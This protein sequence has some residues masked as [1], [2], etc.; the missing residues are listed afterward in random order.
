MAV[1]FYWF[2]ES[3]H[4]LEEESSFRIITGSVFIFFLPGLVWGEVLGF[5]SSHPLETMTLSF[6]LTLSIEVFMLPLPFLFGAP[7]QLWL[8]LIFVVCA[9]GIVLL[10]L[11]GE[12]K[13]SSSFFNGYKQPYPLNVS[14][15]LII[16]TIIIISSAMY[17]WGEALFDIRGEKLLEMF[18]VRYYY[19]LPLHLDSFGV[20][21]GA[22]PPNM[23]HLWEF[24][25]AGWSR[26]IN[27]DPLPLFYRAR[28]II[29]L[30]GYSGMYFLIKNIFSCKVKAE[31]IFWGVIIMSI[32]WFMLFSEFE[33]IR[34]D[35]SRG[36]M[37]FMETVHHGDASTGILIALTAGLLLF[38]F[39]NPDWKNFFIITGVLAANFMWHEREFFQAAVYA[40][41]FGLSLL[42]QPAVNK[43]KSLKR[44]M[45][46]MGAFAVITTLLFL[47]IHIEIP[48][49]S[50]GHDEW[51]IKKFAFRNALQFENLTGVRNFFN[52]PFF[53]NIPPDD[54]LDKILTKEEIFKMFNIMHSIPFL[55][56]SAIA[57]IIL[58]VIGRKE[59][60]KLSLFFVLLWFLTLAWNFSMLMLIVMT[61]SEIHVATPR[62]LYIFSYIIIPA[63]LFE[64]C[65]F[66]ELA[67]KGSRKYVF[68]LS[69]VSCF[70][71]LFN[72][73]WRA[74]TPF[75]DRLSLFL[76]W[77]ILLLSPMMIFSKNPQR[78]EKPHFLCVVAGMILLF[79]PLL[80][81]EYAK[82]VTKIFY[83][84]RQSVDWFGNNN[85]FGLSA[86]LIKFMQSVP[87]K[88]IFLVNPLGKAV[89]PLYAPQYLAVLPEVTPTVISSNTAQEETRNG[90]HPLFNPETSEFKP[91][92]Q[93]KADGYR[94]NGAGLNHASVKEWLNRYH[95]DFVFVQKEY[96]RHLLPYFSRY[97]KDY[98][99]V[100]HNPLAEEF[101]V[102]VY[103]K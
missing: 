58:S 49:Q 98:K 23:I 10:F 26:L 48:K 31:I 79:F 5:R 70:G 7:I 15:A 101:V 32:G 52:F 42:L 89:L 9:I 73:W 63:C 65:R 54:L 57:L 51:Q 67:Y 21:P 55:I 37:A 61:Y 83:A 86:E 66:F 8:A 103:N 97:A 56:L 28:F 46:V 11:K 45:A 95:V 22:P 82:N 33:Y 35:P 102:S 39:Y 92:M 68:F 100:F 71:M 13:F 72:Y 59:D 64:I 81:H 30:L 6:A 80:S 76:T 36:T 77:V 74:G 41:I 3:A 27:S 19:S 14:T 4:P 1:N 88:H 43:A 38:Y 16:L 18:F 94:N 53:L 29:P 93:L 75:W 69:A 96:Y 99:I 40:G 24:L 2:V 90:K 17:R 62:M 84:R 20:Q 85:P 34:E 91:L 78:T 50:Y 12:I 87:P 44:W 47:I 25:I 60:K